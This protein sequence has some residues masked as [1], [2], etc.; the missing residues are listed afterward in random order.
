MS[1]EFTVNG[2]KYCVVNN[3]NYNKE[4]LYQLSCS[5]YYA[6]CLENCGY[7]KSWVKT[8]IYGNTINEVKEKVIENERYK[9]WV[10]C[11]S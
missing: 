4:C 5:K 7:T 6:M 2:T 10:E 8:S 1:R 3:F 11:S 9:L